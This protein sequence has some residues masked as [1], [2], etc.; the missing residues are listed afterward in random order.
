[1]PLRVA[2]ISDLHVDFPEN[3]AAAASV[4][5]ALV[6]ADPDVVIVAGDL[7]P[8]ARLL[9]EALAGLS[10][11]VPRA[12]RLFVPGNHDVWCGL[13]P[14]D[15]GAG[16]SR[17]K[18]EEAIPGI[19]RDAG[20]HPLWADG[21]VVRG[22]VGFCGTMGWYDYGFRADIFAEEADE[23]FARKRYGPL[24]WGDAR[25]A[26]FGE[27]DP[28]VARRLERDLA[29]D[30][31]A[32]AARDEVASIVAVTHVLPY[33]DLVPYSRRGNAAWDYCCAFLGSA[34]LGRTIDEQGGGRVRLV[35]SGHIH[36]P[37]DRDLGGGKRAL[38]APLGY[39]GKEWRGAPDAIARERLRVVEV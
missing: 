2:A 22:G 35:V 4:A 5:A 14:D 28:S 17:V 38:I 19:V 36:I 21:P 33:R 20:F 16:A 32:L 1:M 29:R 9:R 23:F 37:T 11:A 13:G 25:R 3:E 31:A 39:P 15:G 7:S 26:R 18:Y 30:L 10:A 27:D 24:R 6:E 12:L 8:S 34:G